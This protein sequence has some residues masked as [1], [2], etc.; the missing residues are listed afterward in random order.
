MPSVEMCGRLMGSI[1]ETS[2]YITETE[3]IN[4]KQLAVNYIDFTQILLVPLKVHL[5][6]GFSVENLP[7]TFT[8]KGPLSSPHRQ[9]T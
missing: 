2:Q 5:N 4:G 6:P 3:H 9:G 1:L 7:D 8:L